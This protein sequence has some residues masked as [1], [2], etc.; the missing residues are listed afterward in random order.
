MNMYVIYLYNY[1]KLTNTTCRRTKVNRILSCSKT[2]TLTL[3][4]INQKSDSKEPHTGSSDWSDSS[5]WCS[6]AVKHHWKTP[7]SSR[8]II[9]KA[10]VSHIYSLYCNHQMKQCHWNVTGSHC[11]QSN[12]MFPFCSRSFWSW[13]QTWR[14]RSLPTTSSWRTSF[15]CP[16]PLAS[17]S[18]SPWLEWCH[19]V[20]EEAWPSPSLVWVM[21]VAHLG[22]SLSFS[23]ADSYSVLSLTDWLV[24][25]AFFRTRVHQPHGCARPWL[26]WCW[27]GDAHQCIP[28]ELP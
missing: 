28:W 24:L 14:T 9:V 6:T 7:Q 11:R 13:H 27:H 3:S 25:H 2:L 22:L 17:H 21:V 26:C 4:L 12:L 18:S 19:L 20:P 15:H 10:W 23:G 1:C 16:R 5:L 8:I